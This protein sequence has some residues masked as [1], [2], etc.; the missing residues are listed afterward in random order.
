M[1]PSSATASGEGW[2]ECPYP[3]EPGIRIRAGNINDDY[4]DCP[5]SGFDEPGTGACLL[6]RAAVA[7]F[8][9]L[10]A[11]SDGLRQQV[12]RIR[13]NDG[14][15]GRG[16]VL[17]PQLPRSLLT[18]TRAQT[19]LPI[20]CMD[21]SDE[22]GTVDCSIVRTEEGLAEATEWAAAV[23]RGQAEMAARAS[24]ERTR[25]IKRREEI[26]ARIAE[27][28]AALDGVVKDL[29][30][31]KEGKDFVTAALDQIVV[32]LQRDPAVVH[33]MGRAA[34]LV[35]Q[36][37]PDWQAGGVVTTFAEASSRL[38]A[39]LAGIRQLSTDASREGEVDRT[40]GEEPHGLYLA[41]ALECYDSFASLVDDER[42]FT[43]CP[44]RHVTMIGRRYYDGGALE[45]GSLAAAATSLGTWHG[46]WDRTRG[47]AEYGLGEGQVAVRAA[48]RHVCGPHTRIVGATERG[49]S[50]SVIIELETPAA[51]PLSL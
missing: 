6:A 5:L 9:C 36:S 10:S 38:Y 20:D 49:A 2:T 16:A 15:C 23:A 21:G 41:L 37:S 45:R 29:L 26:A 8:Y 13:V 32:V 31:C 51:C 25:V 33:A 7:P 12:D 18:T 24:E 35:A 14:H 27:E 4:C 39:I 1:L 42:V 30:L 19:W 11:G 28:E 46:R 47:V 43:I 22:V 44:F 40:L 50:Q 3:D 34:D 48:V 17:L